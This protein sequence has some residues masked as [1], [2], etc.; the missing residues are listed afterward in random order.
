MKNEKNYMGFLIPKEW[1]IL[2]HFAGAFHQAQNSYFRWVMCL[3]IFCKKLQ[4]KLHLH[5]NTCENTC[6]STHE[7]ACKNACES[8]TQIACMKNPCTRSCIHVHA[9]PCVKWSRWIKLMYELDN[10]SSSLFISQSKGKALTVDPG[11]SPGGLY[12]FSTA[13]PIAETSKI[14]H[15]S[16]IKPLF[17]KSVTELLKKMLQSVIDVKVVTY[18]TQ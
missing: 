2:K 10:S 3:H 8:Y 5:K 15:S 17:L 6:K 11:T 9:T 16:K 14:L 18:I 13:S 7:N 12:N 1:Q 4:G